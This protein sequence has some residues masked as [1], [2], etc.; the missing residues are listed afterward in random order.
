M[1]TYEK[2]EKFLNRLAGAEIIKTEQIASASES[3]KI[4]HV[5]ALDKDK[6]PIDSII[7]A[8]IFI[9]DLRK[10]GMMQFRDLKEDSLLTV[11]FR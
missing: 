11:Q 4:L 6:A 9:F 10:P 8:G 2:L 3:T 1:S 7:A 5:M